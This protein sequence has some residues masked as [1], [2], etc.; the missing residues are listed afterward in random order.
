MDSDSSDESDDGNTGNTM[1][2]NGTNSLGSI[3]DIE[4][5]KERSNELLD[6]SWKANKNKGLLTKMLELEEPSITPKMVDFLLQD[7]VCELLMEF[8]TLCNGT[9]SRPT[10]DDMERE[11]LKLS[12][13]ATMLLSADEPS[14]TLLLFVGKK[15]G[16]M[17]RLLFHSFEENS[18]ASFYHIF[19]IFEFLLRNYPSD[20][21]EGITSDGNLASRISLMLRFV[22]YPPVSDLLVMLICLTPVPRNSQLYVN[23]AKYRWN[24]FE[25]LG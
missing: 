17:A 21:F 20:V 10:H 15:V 3:V 6:T 14:D 25:Q 9:E 22:G 8:V 11:S 24:F 19:R 13:R 16:L 23:C 4:T 5:L 18:A 12:Y 2:S 1:A 7:G